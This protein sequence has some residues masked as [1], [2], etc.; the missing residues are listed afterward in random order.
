MI[1]NVTE[2]LLNLRWGGKYYILSPNQMIDVCKEFGV[3]EN[4]KGVV[5]TRFVNKFS[6]KLIKVEDVIVEE[7][8][9]LETPKTPVKLRG[10]PKKR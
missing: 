1:K 6:G 9:V 2:G 3:D 4:E 7:K 8:V 10:R 5:E